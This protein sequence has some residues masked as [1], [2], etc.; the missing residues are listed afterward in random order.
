MQFNVCRCRGK[1][2]CFEVGAADVYIA[3]EPYRNKHYVLND[4]DNGFDG[5]SDGLMVAFP[6]LTGISF[7]STDSSQQP[8][9]TFAADE[10]H[11]QANHLTTLEHSNR[12]NPS[13]IS[14]FGLSKPEPTNFIKMVKQ[15]PSSNMAPPNS[16]ELNSDFETSKY[17]PFLHDPIYQP[18][19]SYTRTA[20][21]PGSTFNTLMARTLHTPSTI[22]AIQYLYAPPSSIPTIS[23]PSTPKPPVPGHGTLL[24][25]ISLGTEMCSH[26]NVLHGGINTVLVD[27][28]GG[29]LAMKEAPA[30]TSMMAVNFNV[31]LR[32]SVKVEATPTVVLGRAWL[33]RAPEV[34]YSLSQSL[35]M[36]GVS[37]L[38][39]FAGTEVVG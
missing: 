19:P 12:K 1:M 7:C 29:V 18:L 37:R 13:L 26:E 39:G 25:L 17:Q 4:I 38:I 30:G 6:R 14:T 5:G 27:E 22:R 24:A 34:S 8:R 20:P 3:S 28:V 2:E 33:E 32:R 23:S 35:R 31:N 21:S 15:K 16:N 36:Q 9:L 11:L 10:F